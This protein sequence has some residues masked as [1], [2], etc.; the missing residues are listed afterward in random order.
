MKKLLL[1]A[2]AGILLAVSCNKGEELARQT[3]YGDA[4]KAETV[5]YATTEGTALPATKIYADEDLR[6]LWNESDCISIFDNA[7]V[8]DKYMFDGEDGDNSGSFSLEE[9]GA[10]PSVPAELDHIYAV[11]PYSAGTQVSVDQ[12]TVTVAFELP[13]EQLYRERSFGLGANT[14]V[15]VTDG[16]FLGF[17]NVCG[18]L[19]FRFYGDNVTVKSVK[20]EGNNGEKIAGKAVITPSMGSVPTVALD[21]TAT[22]SITMNCA[23]PVTLGTSSTDFTEFIFVIPPTEFSNGFKVT[24]T[25]ENDAVFE[26]ATTR[27]LTIS[28]SK[29]ESMSAMKVTPV[30]VPE[31]VNYTLVTNYA[32]LTEGSEIIIVSTAYDKAMATEMWSSPWRKEADITKSSDKTIVEN[33][34]VDVQ[35]FTLK[36]GSADNTVMFEC[37]NGEFA[38]QYIGAKLTANPTDLSWE[39]LFNCTSATTERG[40]SFNVDLQRN[41]DA[42]IG[43]FD[44]Q[45]NYKYMSY[46]FSNRMFCMEDAYIS[47]YAVA[48]YKLD[49]TGEGDP[50]IVHEPEIQFTSGVN[51]PSG[52]AGM[53]YVGNTMYLPSAG[54]TYTVEFEVKYPVEGGYMQN[55]ININGG[56]YNTIPGLVATMNASENKIVITLPENTDSSIRSAYMIVEYSYKDEAGKWHN[57]KKWL[58]IAQSGHV[59]K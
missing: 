4:N 25:D 17:K 9:E 38:G 5:F 6:V 59:I 15:A 54:G 14:M 18:Y 11:Y 13:A 22:G 33:P 47:N 41:G 57:I 27:S 56:G 21:E 2:V 50:L 3:K 7:N 58:Y 53:D 26:K 12:S 8:N 52:Y 29:M 39:Y 19:K 44:T 34:G 23:E 51:T 48:I 16:N 37:K 28:R 45:N 10:D 35:V 32:E 46:E 49:G 30:P 43:P 55:V 31:P 40:I 20:L 42:L 1:L 24:V 36:K